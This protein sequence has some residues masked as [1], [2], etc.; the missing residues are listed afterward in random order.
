MKKGDWY[1]EEDFYSV[2]KIDAHLHYY[3]RSNTF[4]KHA[5]KC[6]IHLVSINVDF[7]ESEWLPLPEQNQLARFHKQNT[8]QF[9]SYIGAIPMAN[10]VTSESIQAAC[11]HI[12]AEMAGG[13]IGVKLWKNIGM[14]HTY[15]NKLVMI[16]HPVLV[17]LLQYLET[18][19]IPLLGHFGEPLNCWLPVNEMTVESDRRYYQNHPEFHMHLHPHMPAHA[20]HIEACNEVLARHPQLRF[21]GAHLGSSEY[22]IEAIAKRL[23]A[24]PN[25]YMDLAE[26]VCHL[27][28]QAVQ[29][30]Q[31]V[32]DFMIKYQDRL[33]YGSDIVFKDTEDE[34]QLLIEA[35]QRWRSQWCFFTQTN[36]QTT[37]QVNDVFK[38]LGLPKGVIDKIYWL[39]AQKAY[40]LLTPQS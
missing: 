8:P 22:S 15:K 21:I 18:N 19:H 24:Y 28:H 23:D 26:R 36:E 40:P 30:H 34:Q 7:Q 2:K 29:N 12:P 4:L 6:N 39:N 35:E 16:N 32:Y 3:T 37:W 5:Q 10:P 20:D 25:M 11:K 1:S 33:L 27:Q 38:G 17:P 13:A 14:K 31:G 9:Y